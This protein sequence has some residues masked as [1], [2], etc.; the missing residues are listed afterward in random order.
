[1][2]AAEKGSQA[3]ITALIAAGSPVDGTDKFGETALIHAAR[4]GSEKGIRAL[5]AAKASLDITDK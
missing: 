3:T 4:V 2:H 1:M 5:V